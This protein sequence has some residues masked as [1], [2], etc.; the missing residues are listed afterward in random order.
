MQYVQ[1][2]NWQLMLDKSVG[3][4]FSIGIKIFVIVIVTLIGLKCAGIISEKVMNWISKKKKLDEEYLKRAQTLKEIIRETL[5]IF[6]LI[7]GLF[8]I[9]GQI[10]IKIGPFLAAAGVV[11]LAIGFGGQKLVEDV[12]S[13]F[14]IL[15]EDQIRVGD[16]VIIAEKG[17]LVEKVDLRHVVIR[18]L[19]GNVHYVRNGQIGVVTNMTKEFSRY[20]FDIGVAYRE[21][22]DEVIDIIKE[23]DLELRQDP[24]FANFILEPIEVLGLD[25]FADS[26]LVI[27]ARTK[28]KPI[29]QW[30][31]A[32]EFN[33][34]LKKKFDQQGIEIPFPHRT[35]YMGQDKK[36]NAAVLNI[37][38]S[39]QEN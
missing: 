2:L 16:V 12:I 9:L 22:V 19:S 24:E 37:R 31:V 35:L 8:M 1:S 5:S 3:W 33:R 26:A 28:T 11:G 6:I 25:K 18:D 38:N 36:G 7:L 27:K 23:T 20:V 17:G 39:P 21:N 30:A 14:F 15:L 13:G 29:K 10:G 32:R 34:R 4:V